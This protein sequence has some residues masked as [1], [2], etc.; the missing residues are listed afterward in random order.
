MEA[1]SKTRRRR[2][3]GCR[4]IDLGEY[5]ILA[6]ATSID[7]LAVGIS[8][9]ALSVTSFP[10]YRFRLTRLSFRRRRGDRPHLGARYE[11]P[12]TIVGWP[13]TS[14]IGLRSCLSIWGFSHCNE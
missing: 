9:A 10:L 4:E 3:K 1:L 7:A 12:P 5:L 6:I 11:K 14:L 8:F 2:G 13:C